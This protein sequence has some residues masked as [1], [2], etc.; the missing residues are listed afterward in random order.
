LLEVWGRTAGDSALPGRCFK[1]EPTQ[2]TAEQRGNLRDAYPQHAESGAADFGS[3]DTGT[4]R[5]GQRRG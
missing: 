1:A 3:C 5:A 4:W 2:N